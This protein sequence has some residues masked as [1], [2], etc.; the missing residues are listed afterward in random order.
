MKTHTK[1]AMKILRAND[2]QL[3]HPSLERYLDETDEMISAAGGSLVSRQAIAI[4]IRLWQ[5][6][7]LASQPLREVE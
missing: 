6:Q 2:N 4:L 1:L 3:L 7:H 5:V